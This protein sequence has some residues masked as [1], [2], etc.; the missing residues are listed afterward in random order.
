[1]AV[2]GAYGYVVAR[3][4]AME[5]RFL[6]APFINKLVES[7]DLASSLKLLGDTV[8]GPFLSSH[9]S[10]RF[11]EALEAALLDSYMEVRSFVSDVA[12]VDINRVYYDVHNVKVL[13]KSWILAKRGGRRR[14]DLMTSLGS[15]PV[16]ELLEAV[17]SEDYRMLPHG[18]GEVLSRCFSTFEQN[19]DSME[20]EVL[21]DGYY[22]QLLGQMVESSGLDLGGWIREKVDAENLRTLFRLKRMGYDSQKVYSFLH[23]GGNL[24]TSDLQ[25]LLS[26][27]VSSWQRFLYCTSF[28]QLLAG[29][30]EQMS[31]EE[32]MPLLEKAIDDH[33]S[34]YWSGYRYRIDAPENVLAFLWGKEMEVKNVRMILVSKATN[35]DKERVRRLLRHGYP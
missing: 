32:A 25:S 29:I 6:D 10:D 11:D 17:E 18:L 5:H 8:Y 31:M 3:L 20:L 28:G 9:R 24:D 23:V 21:L 30:G 34:Q 27:P 14:W 1:M 4:R 22:F 19:G 15:I 35:Y 12:L 16:D 33:F 2:Q 13:V 7:D 26:E